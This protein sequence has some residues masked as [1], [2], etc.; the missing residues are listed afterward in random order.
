MYSGDSMYAII[1]SMLVVSDGSLFAVMTHPPPSTDEL[2]D[3]VCLE[4][5]TGVAI[6]D[7][8]AHV[9]FHGYRPTLATGGDHGCTPF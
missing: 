3:L 7:H 2:A 6:H 5:M 9:P 4:Y 1:S 8:P